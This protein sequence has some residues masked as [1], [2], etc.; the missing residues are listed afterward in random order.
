MRRYSLEDYITIQE[1][2]YP[3]NAEISEPNTIL[4]QNVID[5]IQFLI[6][7]FKNVPQEE[8]QDY[9]KKQP[10]KKTFTN[11]KQNQFPTVFRKPEP[12]P[13]P[14]KATVIEKKDGIE[15]LINDIKVA[16][17]KISAKNYDQ[18]KDSV[19]QTIQTIFDEMPQ[20]QP[21]RGMSDDGASSGIRKFAGRSVDR[22]A[23]DASNNNTV[24][25]KQNK[26]D[27][28]DDDSSDD[29]SEPIQSSENNLIIQ[30]IFD[31]ASSNKFY[32]EL[33]ARL[34]QTVIDQYQ[35]LHFSN[36]SIMQDYINNIS[37]VEYADSDKDY[38]HYCVINKQNDKRRALTTFIAFL[39]K[40]GVVEVK[41]TQQIIDK[42][43]QYIMTLVDEENKT[44]IVEEIIENLF[45]VI[46][47]LVASRDKSLPATSCLTTDNK[48]S[49]IQ[50]CT[51]KSNDF[52]DATHVEKIT[53]LASYKVKEHKS[54]SSRAIFKV[55]DMKKLLLSR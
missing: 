13:V 11:R 25:I 18:Q 8:E 42:M 40:L 55:G 7:E 24:P 43:I 33:Y 29:E 53:E 16:L 50:S 12:P 23:N 26:F 15:K 5:I 14:F 38:D 35:Q 34:Y 27:L 21:T 2:L 1:T 3:I 46:N 54:I 32:S 9:Y 51:D 28:L 44:H 20:Q 45:I 39:T 37:A 41:T 52:I 19:I 10:N 17:N 4:P 30:S 47:T 6:N 48:S 36:T 31:I 22:D 49:I